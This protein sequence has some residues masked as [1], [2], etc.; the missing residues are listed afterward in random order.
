MLCLGDRP[1]ERHLVRMCFP[2]WEITLRPLFSVLPDH[3]H[4]NI[5]QLGAGAGIFRN[6]YWFG[7]RRKAP[8][9][10]QTWP[11]AIFTH[12]GSCAWI[13][14]AVP[15]TFISLGCLERTLLAILLTM[16]THA[17]IQIHAFTCTHIHISP[18]LQA[19]QTE[20]QQ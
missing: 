12:S 17:Y 13:P 2:A 18:P 11:H 14:T 16:Y 6:G 5:F 20:N 19:W 1:E 15:H 10:S 7:I 3:P 8:V 9:L 4:G